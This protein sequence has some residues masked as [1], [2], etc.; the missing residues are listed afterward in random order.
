MRALVV[1]LFAAAACTPAR[2]TA[3]PDIAAPSPAAAPDSAPPKTASAAQPATTTPPQVPAREEAAAPEVESAPPVPSAPAPKAPA[4]ATKPP[5]T[6]QKAPARTAP[7]KSPPAAAAKAPAPASPPAATA[8][9]APATA[10]APRAA[11]LDIKTLEQRLRET[12]AIGVMTKLSLKNQVDDLL[13]KFR[14]YHRGQLKVALDDLRHPYELLLMKVLSLLQDGDAA[15]AQA[16]NASR[17]AIWA[18][19]ADRDKFF[20]YTS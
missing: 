15:L 9:T 14:E 19:L 1:A 2:Q 10:P 8:A 16:I 5:T 18:V 4:A 20:Q 13:E 11:P 6:A 17:D 7:P 3:P 12:N